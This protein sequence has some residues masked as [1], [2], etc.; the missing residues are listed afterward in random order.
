MSTKDDLKARVRGAVD[1]LTPQLLEVS[2]FIHENP[3]L[4]FKEHKAAKVL[5]DTLHDAGIT[6]R[7]EAYGLRTAFEAEFGRDGGPCVALLAEYDALPGI[8][9]A[10]GHN[11]IATSALGAAL[12]LHGLGDDLPGRIRFLGTPA[13]ERGGGKELMARE[14]AFDGIDA[15]MMVHPAGVDLATMPCIAVA[16]VDIIYHG[17]SAH[18]SAAPQAGI[19]A[20]DALVIAYQALSA[21]RQHIKHTERIH[22][23]IT[24][25]GDA[26][27]VIPERA[28]GRFGVRAADETQLESLKE[29]AN[30]CF[31]AGAL[32][33]GAR[34]EVKWGNVDYLDLNTCWPLA[35]AYQSNAESLGRSF[36]PFD[37]LP[38][39][40]AGS[41][42]MGNISYRVPSIHPMITC[43]PAHVTIHNPEFEK[44]AGSDL[45]ENATADGAK[46]LAMT[47]LDFLLDSDLRDAAKSAY[48]K[49]LA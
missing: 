8:G 14:G 12:A 3:E 32:A 22:G 36:F 13:E 38:S 24:H 42:D 20:L 33:T 28:S 31:E 39:S 17:R 15:A 7:K 37:K 40:V 6:V 44:W 41:T 47:T 30:Q 9:H 18:A 49:G 29:R 11:I 46:A 4:A 26:A 2:H 25:G 48:E 27:N 5:T 10:C 35:N 1:D 45:G 19:N 21:L 23:I 34:A 43:A 16:D